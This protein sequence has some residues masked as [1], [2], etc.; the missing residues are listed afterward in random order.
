VSRQDRQHEEIM[1]ALSRR[2]YARV[3]VL[4]RE[5]LVE[6]PDDVEVGWAADQARR[7]YARKTSSD[8]A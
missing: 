3:L 7:H 4:S 5:H 2:L 6:F 1:S 8:E